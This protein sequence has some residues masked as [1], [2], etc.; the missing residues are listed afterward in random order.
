[1]STGLDERID[2][3]SS[4]GIR[5]RAWIDDDHRH[6]NGLLVEQLLFAETVIA[7]VV[8]V[9]GGEDDQR[10]TGAPGAIE[11]IEHA[12]QMVVDLLHQPHV[13]RADMA[14]DVL[15]TVAQT[16]LVHLAIRLQHRVR[17]LPVGIGLDDA[18]GI[19]RP[20]HLVVRRRRHQRPVRLDVGDVQY[21]R[22][23][24]RRAHEF[25]RA[26]RHVG[27]LGMLLADDGG[28]VRISQQ[29]AVRLRS[30]VRPA[31]RRHS[32]STGRRRS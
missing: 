19:R 15:A 1:M 13:G 8:A 26:I 10:A 31:R 29:P 14:D 22:A 20:V 30:A 24:R 16:V 5:A 21:T 12:L 9:V 4:R 7:Q 18:A 25:D 11:A 23:G 6:P 32:R 2:H 17:V 27:G 28:Q 3:A